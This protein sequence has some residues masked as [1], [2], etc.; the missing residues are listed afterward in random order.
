LSV[1]EARQ[2]SSSGVGE[3]AGGGVVLSE[4]TL[5]DKPRVA[6]RI[7][8]DEFGRRF[9]RVQEPVLGT[10]GARIRERLLQRIMHDL[11]LLRKFS[12][13]EDLVEGMRE[14][15]RLA[16]PWA[17]IWSKLARREGRSSEEEALA[18]A[19]YVARDL[20]GYGVLDPLIRDPHIEDI[21]CNG[22]FTPVFVYHDRF[23]WLTTE[24]VFNS[25]EE[26]ESLVMKIAVRS[27]QE[28]SLAQ[29][30]VEGVLKP[31]G[32]RVHIVLNVVSRKGHSFTI[33]KFRA[34]P[35]TIVEL[36]NNKTLEPGLAAFL[37]AAIQYKQGVVIY[38]PTGSGKTT[39]LNAL[40]MM[41]PPEYKVVTIEDTPEVYL[42]FHENWTA[43]HT[44][45]SD[46]PG[47]QSITLQ[48]QV[49]SALRMRPDV[50]IVG[51]IRSR[52]AFAF[53]QALATGHGGLTTI[54]AENARV[55]IRRLSSPPM[56][57]PRSLIAAAKLYV[58][59]LRIEK[60]GLVMRRVVWVDETLGYSVD[61]DE[62]ELRRLFSWRRGEDKWLFS[63]GESGFINSLAMLLA[64][65]ERDVWRDLEM[66]ATVLYWAME[67]SMDIIELHEV[68]RKYMREPDTV[69]QQALR[70]G[71]QPYSFGV[72]A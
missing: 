36:L 35:F 52:E 23:E 37:W 34:E 28:P 31:E 43:L 33:R 22:L 51:E 4:Y 59:I 14:A 62:I 12:E 60:G 50:I 42:P 69:Y 3:G 5:L 54:H 26:L 6:V 56:N 71:V 44:R 29:P 68:V 19:Y 30:V 25:V 53:F 41:L 72:E 1:G 9:Y 40:A 58:G 8:E 17:R 11:E 48:S 47:V 63:R 15:L 66:R 45:I 20:T 16:R 57:V 46:M 7:V 13:L 55:L 24:I 70:E 21:S 10:V 39:L 61:R 38:G 27:G 32:Y 18:A 67:K 65:D 49:E 64:V 2:A